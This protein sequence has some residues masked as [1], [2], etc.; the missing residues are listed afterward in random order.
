MSTECFIQFNEEGEPERFLTLEQAQNFPRG[1][2]C[3]VYTQDEYVDMMRV[4]NNNFQTAKFAGKLIRD[5][6]FTIPHP[7]FYPD[8][9]QK[10]GEDWTEFTKHAKDH[11]LIIE[12]LIDLLTQDA[13]TAEQTKFILKNVGVIV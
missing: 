3:H 5:L 1:E 10:F 7:E 8:E 2:L 9:Y 13:E 12:L 6:G 4:G 11:R